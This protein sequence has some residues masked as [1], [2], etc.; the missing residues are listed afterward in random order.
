MTVE[1]TNRGVSRIWSA[2]V[3]GRTM[4]NPNEYWFRA[5]RYGWGWG[6]PSSSA[7]WVFFLVWLVTL[8]GGCAWLRRFNGLVPELFLGFMTALLVLVCYAKGEPPSWR[9]GD[10]QE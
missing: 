3:R 1:M 9:W 7:G 10:R 8:V 5:K 2:H 4:S 6:L